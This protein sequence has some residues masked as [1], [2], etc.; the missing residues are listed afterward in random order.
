M[1]SGRWQARYSID[2]DL[3]EIGASSAEAGTSLSVAAAATI[4]VSEST[5]AVLVRVGVFKPLYMFSLD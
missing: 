5:E 1:W 4:P 2:D 3:L